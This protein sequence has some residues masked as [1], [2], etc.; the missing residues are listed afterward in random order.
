MSELEKLQKDLNSKKY[1]ES[2]SAVLADT[3]KVWISELSKNIQFLL[4]AP[5]WSKHQVTIWLQKWEEEFIKQKESDV[6]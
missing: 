6:K 4:W 5:G 3:F 1:K 2:L